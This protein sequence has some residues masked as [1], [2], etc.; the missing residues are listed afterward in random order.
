MPGAQ[1]TGAVIT[2]N[3]LHDNATE[4]LVLTAG[5]HGS[6]ISGNTV[7]GSMANGIRVAAG[8]NQNVLTDN[9]ALDNNTDGTGTGTDARDADCWPTADPDLEPVD[10]HDLRRRCSCGA[11]LRAAGHRGRWVS[12]TLSPP[13]A[14]AGGAGAT[15][16]AG[17]P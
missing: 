9:V 1:P 12:R 7:T 2:G 4:G 16:A 10:P 3:R 8:A 14:A 5:N 6:T 17:A 13:S 11:D 15:R